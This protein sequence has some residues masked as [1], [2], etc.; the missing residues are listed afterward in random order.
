ML[1]PLNDEIDFRVKR[2]IGS[3]YSTEEDDIL[4]T[5]SALMR[6]G[7]YKPP[8]WGLTGITDDDMFAGLKKFQK[9]EGLAVDGI[10]KPGG[11]TERRLNARLRTQ[12]RTATGTV[13]NGVPGTIP[14]ASRGIAPGEWDAL[15]RVTG[16]PQLPKQPQRPD[17]KKPTADGTE[18]A[19]LG[20]LMHL[21]ARVA[22]QVLRTLP[23]L[24]GLAD[25]ARQEAAKR[26]G[27][28]RANPPTIP[29]IPQDW[30][31]KQ[32]PSNRQQA[33]P[34]PPIPGYEPPDDD[35]PDREEYPAEIDL[36][37]ATEI[38]P[39]PGERKATLETFPIEDSLG[40]WI[41]LEHSRGD[42]ETQDKND[43]MIEIYT[44]A[45]KKRGIPGRRRF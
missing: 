17:S 24:I 30:L 9:R 14:G 31:E 12:G 3:S 6:T 18:V 44:A 15:D 25:K 43:I 27:D 33:E 23:P 36:G 34:L 10:M 40:Q 28:E 11:P 16:F 26:N 39:D 21:G 35:R 37:P 2:T 32:T 4:K 41:I 22:P 20:P 38:F 8:Q 19:F 5:K 29:P 7:D 13:P 1:N 42:E 45:M